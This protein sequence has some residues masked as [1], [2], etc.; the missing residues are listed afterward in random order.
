MIR[1]LCA[2]KMTTN[3]RR[4]SLLEM[5]SGTTDLSFDSTDSSSNLTKYGDSD[6][7]S[8][9][10]K[11]CPEASTSECGDGLDDSF[12]AAHFA[13]NAISD[14]CNSTLTS[15]DDDNP[16]SYQKSSKKLP[17]EP[18]MVQPITSNPSDVS[19]GLD[20]TFTVLEQQLEYKYSPQFTSQQIQYL[21]RRSR[22]TKNIGLL[23]QNLL[24]TITEEEMND[25]SADMDEAEHPS[26]FEL[27]LEA[28][29][30]IRRLYNDKTSG[31]VAE[32][33]G[34]SIPP[35]TPLHE[36]L[37]GFT[38]THHAPVH[39][40]NEDVTEVVTENSGEYPECVYH[41]ARGPDK[42]LY[43]RVVRSLLV[44]KGKYNS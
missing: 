36:M 35:Q 1:K 42:R 14:D 12:Y 24:K 34:G 4:K 44:D 10:R 37:Y 27:E 38:P 40:L 30:R 8:K 26:L 11:E 7:T 19:L 29:Q 15:A 20:N 18:K 9:K 25:E 21:L 31:E 39:R 13:G 2:N 28:S 17:T 43:L 5:L 32:A 16:R 6:L 23:S 3:N 22:V 41:V 33:A